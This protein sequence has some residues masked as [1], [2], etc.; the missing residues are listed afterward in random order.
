MTYVVVIVKLKFCLN[1]LYS[2]YL[3]V[4]SNFDV[5]FSLWT[6]KTQLFCLV[7]ILL[8]SLT[9]RFISVDYTKYLICILCSVIADES[10]IESLNNIFSIHCRYFNCCVSCLFFVSVFFSKRTCDE[11]FFLLLDTCWHHVFAV[12]SLTIQWELINC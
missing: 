6:K 11:Y 1:I 2:S 5:Y 7:L 12:N 8:Y 3:V 9:F 4:I 10:V